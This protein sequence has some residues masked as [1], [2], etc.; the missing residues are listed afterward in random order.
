MI[1]PVNASAWMKQL[2][3]ILALFFAFTVHAAERKIAI[4]RW[5]LTV[6]ETTEAHLSEGPDFSVTYLNFPELHTS[7]GIYEG[8]F[9]RSFSEGHQNV[10]RQPD[11][12]AGISVQWSVWE[13]DAKRGAGAETTVVFPDTQ[14]HLFITAPSVIGLEATRKIVR[15][16]R[17]I[18]EGEQVEKLPRP[19]PEPEPPPPPPRRDS[20]SPVGFRT[21]AVSSGNLGDP[22]LAYFLNHCDIVARSPYMGESSWRDD[23][24]LGYRILGVTEQGN[25]VGGGPRSVIIVTISTYQDTPD[26]NIRC[27]RIDGAHFWKFLGVDEWKAEETNGYFLS[28][29]FETTPTIHLSE[30]YRV[31]VGFQGTSITKLSETSEPFVRREPPKPK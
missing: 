10:S 23:H 31:K 4:A 9:P 3:S 29:R 30:I 5:C 26:G 20:T 8:G 7:I 11:S 22:D 28:F 18:R 6:P 15:T 25:F 19:P 2:G 14:L 13:G 12:I 17:E 24:H 27:Y 16:L 1:T 21:A